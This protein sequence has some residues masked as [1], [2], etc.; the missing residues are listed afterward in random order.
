MYDACFHDAL[1]EI[2]FTRKLLSVVA[3]FQQRVALLVELEYGTVFGL[4]IGE[5]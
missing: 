2:R 3:Q 1:Y 4:S 5:V